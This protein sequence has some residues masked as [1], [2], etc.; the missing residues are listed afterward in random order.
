VTALQQKVRRTILR[1]AL[2][3]PG[4][5]VLVGL[6]G[7]GDSVA[8]TLLLRDLAKHGGFTLLGLA[9]F[10]HRLRP[11]ADADERFCRELAGRLSLPL[12]VEEADVAQYAASNRLSIENA[13]RR[14]RYDFL[15]RT[16]ERTGAHR[17]AVGHTE[18]DQAETFLLK[19][20]R[21]AGLS[22][23]G[24]VYPQRGV[25]VR[26]LLD[27]SRRAL[28]EYLSAQ[29]EA[30]VEDETN[31]ALDNPRNRVR[32]RVVPELEQVAGGHIVPALSRAAA[33]AREDGTWLDELGERRFAELVRRSAE[34]LELPVDALTDEPPPIRRRVLLMAMREMAGG[35]EVGAE[36]V[37]AALGLLAGLGSAA[38]IPG[39]RIERR[40]EK[41]VVRDQRTTSK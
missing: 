22:G 29:G 25:V 7:G 24:G 11:A 18:D 33:L 6:S 36:H 16:A 26:P 13:A 15:H 30:W 38:D 20:I 5:Q 9:H 10:N 41:L 3:P 31:E 4:T 34:G 40:A 12:R 23:L 2:L 39:S 8:L 32:H 35:R 19:L 14:L 1:H 28:R 27:V 21:G 37:D 17:I